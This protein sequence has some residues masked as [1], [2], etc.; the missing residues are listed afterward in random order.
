MMI[1]TNSNCNYYDAE[2]DGHDE[3]KNNLDAPPPVNVN[4]FDMTPAEKEAANIDNMPASLIEAIEIFKENP[5]AHS[6]KRSKYIL[7]TDPHGHTR[8]E[9]KVCVRL[10]LINT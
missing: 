10:W 7:A 9:I 3:I 5:I 2:D 8:T 1:L 6:T 4:I